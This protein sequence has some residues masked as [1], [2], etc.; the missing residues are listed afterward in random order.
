MGQVSSAE[1][2]LKVKHEPISAAH[3]ARMSDVPCAVPSIL[4]TKEPQV[5]ATPLHTWSSTVVETDPGV[6]P[7]DQA[8]ACITVR[9]RDTVRFI[10]LNGFRTLRLQW[11]NESVLSVW[12]DVG[13]I[14][15]VLQLFDLDEGKR[16]YA[17]TERYLTTEQ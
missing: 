11:L 7:Y 9:G 17:Q 13:H 10:T 2:S 16:L 3:E 14:A 15:T 12:T 4:R 8:R 6:V 1:A 5:L